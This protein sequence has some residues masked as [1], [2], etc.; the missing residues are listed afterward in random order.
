VSELDK[1]HVILIG[2]VPNMEIIEEHLAKLGIPTIK[3]SVDSALEM[4]LPAP[5]K[6]GDPAPVTNLYVIGNDIPD[7]ERVRLVEWL[8]EGWWSLHLCE[9]AESRSSDRHL[10]VPLHRAEPASGTN[11]WIAGKVF[12]KSLEF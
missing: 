2:D 12:G 9:N 8:R 11:R 6:A 4:L 10:A 1:K 7:V 3:Q 5:Y